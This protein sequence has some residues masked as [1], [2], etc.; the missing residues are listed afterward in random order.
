V[1]DPVAGMTRGAAEVAT[2]RQCDRGGCALG[3]GA[4]VPVGVGHGPSEEIGRW[5]QLLWARPNE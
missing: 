5:A 2:V 1:G 4:G 3:W